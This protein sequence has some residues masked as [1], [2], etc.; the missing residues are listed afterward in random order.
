MMNRRS[1][2]GQTWPGFYNW[3]ARTFP[4]KPLM[5]AEWGVWFSRNNPGHQADFFNSARLQLELFPRVKSYVYFETPDAEGRDSR[6][7]NTSKGLAEY[8]RFSEH[9]A[10]D[11]RFG[12]R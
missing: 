1:G 2:D 3:A 9:R 11:V 4:D 10:F 6:V 12:R 7:Q 8:R 5:L